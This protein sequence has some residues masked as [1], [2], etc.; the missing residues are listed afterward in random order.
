MNANHEAI[1]I[2]L[3]KLQFDPYTQLAMFDND[4]SAVVWFAMATLKNGKT[5]KIDLTSKKGDLG[6]L[7][8]PFGYNLFTMEQGRWHRIATE[9]VAAI[10]GMTL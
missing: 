8:N 5:I 6:G 10:D 1:A 9:N 3:Y 7:D 2:K 4:E